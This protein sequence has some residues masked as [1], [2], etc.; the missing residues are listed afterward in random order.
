MIGTHKLLQDGIKFHNLGLVIIDEEHRFGV[1]QKEKFKAMRAEI[2]VL[3]LT[4]TP[5]PRT[6]NMALTELR[7]LSIIAT[8]PSR[9]LPIKTFVREW[10]DS[11]LKEAFLREIKRGGQVYFLHN[12]VEN[13]ESMASKISQLIPEGRV[14]FA[15]GQ[16][17]EKELEQVMLD[18]IINDLM[19]L[20]VRRLSKRGS[21]YPMPIQS[22]LTEQIN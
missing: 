18:V 2:D 3:T 5:I 6:L 9:R 16:M 17:P 22:L 13:I 1:R 7:D 21:M 4:A 15:H 14:R 20:F 11:L 10:N 12:K 19:S 8:P